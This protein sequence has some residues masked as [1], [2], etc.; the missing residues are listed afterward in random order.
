[1]KLP[2]YKVDAFTTI[3]FQGNPAAVCLLEAPLEEDI[4]KAIAREM[5]LS[6]TAFVMPAAGAGMVSGVGAGGD[7]SGD[8]YSGG[9][10]SLRWFTP[11]V[12]VPLCGHGTLSTAKVLFDEVGVGARELRFE[13]RSGLLKA[14]KA[15]DGVMLDFPLD[16][17]VK[18]AAPPGIIKTLGNPRVLNCAYGRATKKLLVQLEDQESV[19]KLAPNFSALK[20]AESDMEIKGLIVTAAIGSGNMEGQGNA[21]AQE[22]AP[23]PGTAY[24]FVSRY[25]AVWV[26][27]DEDP[28]TGS[29]HTVL[30]PYWGKMLGKNRMRAYQASSRGG[31][32]E[33][34]LPGN[35][36]CPGKHPDDARP[37]D[38]YPGNPGDLE[39]VEVDRNRVGLIGRAVVVEKG[40]LIF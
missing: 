16:D 6:E 37:D 30:A 2:L 31:E 26:G 3:P 15:N 10:Y 19:V 24:D 29:S 11:R 1:M 34:I 8:N 13:T 9:C 12:E 39:G 5:N 25:F 35:G 27:I 7:Y 38:A 40:H 32:M 4:M 22:N 28:V 36:A 23:M 33:V 20:L 21:A 14:V 17:P 18:V